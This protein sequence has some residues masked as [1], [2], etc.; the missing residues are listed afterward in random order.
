MSE[1]QPPSSPHGFPRLSL[2]QCGHCGRTT[3]CDRVEILDFIR[4][5]WPQCCQQDMDLFIEAERPRFG[6]TV[7][8]LPLSLPGSN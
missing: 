5:I 4:A 6:D 2:L 1:D 8:A 3:A 7:V